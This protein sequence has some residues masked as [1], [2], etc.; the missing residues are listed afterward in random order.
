M[1]AAISSPESRKLLRHQATRY[2]R[3][4]LHRGKQDCVEVCLGRPL[5]SLAT[6]RW[7]AQELRNY[8]PVGITNSMRRNTN[9]G[10]ALGSDRSFAVRGLFDDLLQ[11]DGQRVQT[12]PEAGSSPCVGND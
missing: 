11:N 9:V 5:V 1:E 2:E 6:S 4:L 7:K 12:R 8:R 3:R 10:V